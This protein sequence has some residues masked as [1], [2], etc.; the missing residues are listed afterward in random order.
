MRANDWNFI[1]NCVKKL[2]SSLMC[3]RVTLNKTAS[4]ASELNVLVDIQHLAKMGI[5]I[6]SG[7]FFECL[8][9]YL[10]KN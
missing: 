1:D 2:T 5:C 7:R 8:P 3:V 9:D 4:V 6:N 10:L